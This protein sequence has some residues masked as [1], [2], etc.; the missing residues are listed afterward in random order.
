MWGL[1]NRLDN[2]QPIG[3]YMENSKFKK[4]ALMGI[5]GGIILASQSPVSLNASTEIGST[6]AAGCGK[7]S[8]RKGQLAESCGSRPNPQQQ[9]RTYSPEN[10]ASSC[11]SKSSSCSSK[12]RPNSPEI[13]ASCG[14]RPKSPQQQYPTYSAE[15]ANFEARPEN[16]SQT[17]SC[18]T[19]PQAQGQRPRNF[20]AD[21]QK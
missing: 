1:L 21:N 9:Y 3:I 5:T 15:N 2:N 12:S 4:L 13:T 17:A 16:N 7:C 18:G 8:A 20:T 19:R 6:L 11:S 10:N 14:S